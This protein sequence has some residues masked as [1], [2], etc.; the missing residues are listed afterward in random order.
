V[1]KVIHNHFYRVDNSFTVRE[2]A[3]SSARVPGLVYVDLHIRQWDVLPSGWRCHNWKYLATHE[4]SEKEAM[5]RMGFRPYLPRLTQQHIYLFC[6]TNIAIPAELAAVVADGGKKS[7]YNHHMDGL[8]A[9][10]E[11][12]AANYPPPDPFIKP[13]IAL[14]ALS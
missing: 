1:R 6:H 8:L 9:R 2:G 13:E 14:E 7:E 5:L 3:I 12:E 11:N 10:I 4:Q